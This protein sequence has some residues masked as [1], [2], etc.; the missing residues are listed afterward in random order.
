VKRDLAKLA[1]TA[2][3]GGIDPR[4]LRRICATYLRN[5]AAAQ[6]QLRHASVETTKRH[7]LKAIPAEQK[8]R[9]ERLDLE[10]FEP[11]KVFEMRRAKR[12]A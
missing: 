9:V 4:R 1:R 6:G 3:V 11:R 2:G 5:K 10:L 12:P 7:Y 8:E